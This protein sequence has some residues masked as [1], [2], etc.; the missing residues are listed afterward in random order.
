MNL[1]VKRNISN[2]LWSSFSFICLISCF[3]CAQKSIQLKVTDKLK[4]EINFVSIVATTDSLETDIVAYTSKSSKGIYILNLPGKNQQDSLW[5]TLR[6]VSH[7]VKK[8]FVA[9]ES[10]ILS[11]QLEK[12]ENQL[13]EIFLEAKKSLVIK[14]DTLSFDVKS[15]QKQKDYTIED[16]IARIPGVTIKSDGAITYNGRLI[17]HFYINGLDLLEG[18]YNLATR[19]IPGTAVD[20]IQVLTKHNHALI[21]QGK[22][23]S[24]KVAININIDKEN[25]IFGSSKG[26]IG[27]P[28]PLYNAELTPVLINK[29]LQNLLT[30]KTNQIG[31]DLSVEGKKLTSVDYAIKSIS[32]EEFTLLKEPNTEGQ[33]IPEKYW[34]D[35]TSLSFSNDLLFKNKNST[36]YKLGLRYNQNDNYFLNRTN[37]NYFTGSDQ[38]AVNNISE[39]NFDNSNFTSSF[40]IE[41]NKKEKFS[42]NKLFLNFK[43][44]KGSSV[45]LLNNLPVDY[46]FE[47]QQIQ[48][49]N[50][51]EFKKHIG[52]TLV[53]NVFIAQYQKNEEESF[54][55]PLVFQSQIPTFLDSEN[56]SQQ[57]NFQSLNLGSSTQFNFSTGKLNWDINQKL[58]WRSEQLKTLLFQEPQQFDVL[59]PFK[60]DFNLNTFNSSTDLSTSYRYKKIITSLNT[61]FEFN[62]LTRNDKFNQD[63]KAND[64]FF[65]IQPRLSL[66]YE[67]NDKLSINIA[68][69]YNTKISNLSNLF[70]ALILQDYL[71]LSV[72]PTQ[73]NQ[74][75][76]LTTS[77]YSSY[78]NI[79]KGFYA[80]L[81][82]SNTK[83][84]SG[85]TFTS[86]I[87]NN[88]LNAINAL[89]RDNETSTI[90]ING[91]VTKKIIN[92]MLLTADF[93]YLSSQTQSFFNNNLLNINNDRYEVG[94][95]WSYDIRSWYGLE[96]NG[97][98]E[99][100]ISS[101][102]QSSNSNQN[103]R[104]AFDFS[105]YLN[106]K[107]RFNIGGEVLR[108]SF[109]EDSN[110][111]TN[112]LFNSSYHYQPSKKIKLRLELL[113]IFDIKNYTIISNNA[114][115]TSQY[116]YQLRPRQFNIGFTYTL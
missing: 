63:T 99:K 3:A 86:T 45:N 107:S 21:D 5:L 74:T 88:G 24:D 49:E 64:N 42:K 106:S 10:T 109:S 54:A 32:Q 38:T 75:S 16:V 58:F 104:G 65:F 113:N 15:L 90:S 37:T 95:K 96:I 55:S 39:N 57:V 68:T 97:N 36:E 101:F 94:L 70:P 35:N 111:N 43:N 26:D 41:N 116:Q 91:D 8:V 9:N 27:V 76:S 80:N 78:K 72:N 108:T 33:S 87:D 13:D 85:F 46:L 115:F 51:Y 11:I 52:N 89:D 22:T 31:K 60:S 29:N 61:S 34:R 44:S 18:K 114:N 83:S 98:Y 62:N 102:A 2:N 110:V 19:G 20:D 69:S 30:V 17:S 56:T 73:I 7:D 25:V 67:F 93:S 47:R 40:V 81:R 50:T 105:F 77:F 53:N 66:K 1:I 12:N 59:F 103:L 23:N 82:V 100:G 79:I 28:I 92:G 4:K 84:I 14:G 6:H 112:S 48:I 71:T